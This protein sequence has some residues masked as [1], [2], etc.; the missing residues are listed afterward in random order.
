MPENRSQ[1]PA[2]L[3]EEHALR[4]PAGDP[5]SPLPDHPET[6]LLE[7]FLRG[8][9]D[10]AERRT[11]VRHLLTGCP[12]CVAVTRRSWPWGPR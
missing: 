12:R 11:V 4:H 2:Q 3:P 10:E 9:L 8:E 1:H 6:R 5:S 7:D